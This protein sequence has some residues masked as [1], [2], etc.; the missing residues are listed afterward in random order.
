MTPSIP[1][2]LPLVAADPLAASA[3]PLNRAHALNAGV[4]H[5][6]FPGG[7]DAAAAEFEAV[8][9]GQ[10]LKPMFEGLS[11]DG[12]FGGGHAEKTWRSFMV[13][14]LGEEVAQNGGLGLAD[15]VRA[16]MLNAAG[17]TPQTTLSEEE[18]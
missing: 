3:S 7:V 14:A 4:A 12:P 6:A 8:F 11:T 5:A 13:E 2:S 17:A 16:A 1:S 10:M 15:A 18:G 9:I